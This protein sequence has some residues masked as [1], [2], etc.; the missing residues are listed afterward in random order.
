MFDYVINYIQE[1]QTF[2]IVW[3]L[4]VPPIAWLLWK[5]VE[6]TTPVGVDLDEL[7]DAEDNL[8]GMPDAD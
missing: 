7:F 8:E 3:I 1:N 2:F 5:Y 4:V 6:K